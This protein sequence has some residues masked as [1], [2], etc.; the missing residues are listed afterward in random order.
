MLVRL[1]VPINRKLRCFDLVSHSGVRF[2][3]KIEM[4]QGLSP[5]GFTRS[6]RYL[7]I[8]WI[9]L[10]LPLAVSRAIRTRHHYGVAVRIA[11]P[12]LPVIRAAVT[13]RR[14]A[15][16]RLDDLSTKFRGASDDG[17]EI[18]HFEPEQK[19]VTVWL[20]IG[21]GNGTVVVLHLEAVQLE[22]KTPI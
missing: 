20:V 15:M 3:T 11:H 14:I 10:R 1:Y 7:P 4:V 17:V 21:I 18:I 9:A 22:Y 12:A 19:A 2:E 6:F 5:D 16:T 13:I 8:E